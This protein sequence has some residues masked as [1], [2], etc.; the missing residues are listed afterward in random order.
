MAA[1]FRFPSRLYPIVDPSG[2]PYPDHVTLAKAI[3]EGGAA[4][5]QLRCKGMETRSFVACAHAVQALCAAHGAKL[6]VNDRAD[7]ALLVQAAGV[8]L[9]QNDLP[10]VVVRPWLGIKPII[11]F[12]THNV[13]QA[14]VAA[15]LG[16]VDYIGVGP[17]FPTTSKE[18]PDPVVGLEGLREIRRAV[19]LP[20]VAIGGITPETMEQVLAAGADAVAMI[21]ALARSSNATATVRELL[22]R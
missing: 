21:G 19:N 8:H 17:I 5:L 18:N 20:I 3:L 22:Q 16:V 9:G 14:R 12:S 11:G 6:I 7:I 15:E 13:T 2:G 1:T 4:F 10:P